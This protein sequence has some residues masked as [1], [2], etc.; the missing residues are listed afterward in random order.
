MKSYLQTFGFLSFLALTGCATG[1]LDADGSKVAIATS[2]T[3]G[4]VENYDELGPVKKCD[5]L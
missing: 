2:M 5:W 3:A 1:I 4:E